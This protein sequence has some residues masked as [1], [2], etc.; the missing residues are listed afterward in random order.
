MKKLILLLTISMM[1]NTILA[2]NFYNLGTLAPKGSFAVWKVYDGDTFT[3]LLPNHQRFNIRINGID[4]PERRQEYGMYARAY[5]IQLIN[6]QR[7]TIIPLTIDKYGR[8]LATCYTSDG[9]DISLEMLKA[10]MAWHYSDYDNTTAYKEAEQE[11][12]YCGEGIWGNGNAL[13][14]QLYRSLTRTHK[15]KYQ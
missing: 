7:V 12:R 6:G 14:P 2:Q 15:P 11:A 5:L 13:N 8:T 4:A 10:G 9:K 3:I 1:V